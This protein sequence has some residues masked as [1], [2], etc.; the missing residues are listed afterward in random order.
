MPV[1]MASRN[2]LISRREAGL[3]R[4]EKAISRISELSPHQKLVEAPRV[5]PEAV[6]SPA[7]WRST[8]LQ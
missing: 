7:S 5:S 1:R 4:A 6:A 2:P 3:K 8:I